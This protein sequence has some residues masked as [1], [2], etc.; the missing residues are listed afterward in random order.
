M[1]ASVLELFC[2]EGW[3]ERHPDHQHR[4]WRSHRRGST[5]RR[6]RGG[7]GG[8]RGAR[9]FCQRADGRSPPADAAA[10]G[11]DPA[12]RRLDTRGA[13]A[14]GRRDGGGRA[15]LPAR[16]HHPERGQLPVGV[17]R[18]V[19]PP[20]PVHRV[21]RA[22]GRVPGADE[23]R[24]HPQAERQVLRRSGGGTTLSSTP[25]SSGC[26]VRFCRPGSRL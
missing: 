12:H 15:R 19:Q 6:D 16:R 9:R 4:T 17:R 18:R 21:Q 25:C 11:G 5:G 13:G 26:S 22:P 23:R 10:G 8:R 2:A 14:R 1:P 7:P 20:A 24:A 3:E